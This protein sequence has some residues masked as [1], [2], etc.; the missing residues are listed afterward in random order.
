MF[1]NSYIPYPLPSI[2]VEHSE[3]TAQSIQIIADGYPA[4]GF[5]VFWWNRDARVTNSFPSIT[6]FV[7]SHPGIGLAG[8]CLH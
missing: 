4:N 7:V 1:L 6:P 5:K 2:K 8:R 3:A